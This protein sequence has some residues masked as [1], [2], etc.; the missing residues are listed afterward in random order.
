MFFIGIYES[1]VTYSQVWWPILGIC[2]LQL[3][4][5]VHTHSSEH[6]AGSSGQPFMLLCPGSSW[7]F[8]ALLKGTSVVVLKVERACLWFHEEHLISMEPFNCTKVSLDFQNVV[9]RTVHWKFNWGTQNSY[10]MA[11]L[12]NLYFNKECNTNGIFNINSL[13]NLLRFHCC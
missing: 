7:G 13:K 3:P 12:Q 2:A 6:T 10:C 5:Q 8:D 1:D 11:S 4:T 9:L